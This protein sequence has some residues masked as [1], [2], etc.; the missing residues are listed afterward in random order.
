MDLGPLDLVCLLAG[1]ELHAGCRERCREGVACCSGGRAGRL[2]SVSGR[3][4][5]HH[6]QLAAS[7]GLSSCSAQQHA[8]PLP[9]APALSVC[10]ELFHLLQCAA[11]SSPQALA[12]GQ[13]CSQIPLVG[14]LPVNSFPCHTT[15]RISSR[16][17][18][19]SSTVTARRS[20]EPGSWLFN[21]IR[22]S[23]SQQ[24][25]PTPT[26]E[27]SCLGAPAQLRG[28]SATP[29]FFRVLFTSD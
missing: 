12:L 22:T 29:A 24:A 4:A 18:R 8:A 14:P 27:G 20:S 15:G 2:C 25:P 17:H 19:H 9:R 23:A 11:D 1:P 6:Q 7:P 16:C 21:K 28:C 10:R 26:P 13:F 3:L 5:Q